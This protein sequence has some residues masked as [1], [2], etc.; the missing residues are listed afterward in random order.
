MNLKNKTKKEL[1]A[2][3]KKLELKTDNLSIDCLTQLDE[4]KEEL[5]DAQDEVDGLRSEIEELQAENERLQDDS[6]TLEELEDVFEAVS[7]AHFQIKTLLDNR[8]L[9]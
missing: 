9:Q 4:L 1:I 5:E 6:V 3:I 7:E 2:I 8:H